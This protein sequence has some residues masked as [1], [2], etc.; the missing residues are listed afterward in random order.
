[1]RPLAGPLSVPGLPAHDRGRRAARAPVEATIVLGFN[2][3]AELERLVGD[4][5]NPGS[6]RFRRFLTRAQ[7]AARFSPTREQ[8]GR[9]LSALRAAGFTISQTYADRTQI[10][11]RGPSAVA[12]HF[13]STKIHDF[14]QRGTGVRY[15][16]VRA[17]RVPAS[18]A[19]LVRDV[20][21][22]SIVFARSNYA[23][24][25]ESVK[26]P[27]AI[28]NGGFEQKSLDWRACG[29]PVITTKHPYAG[30]YDAQLGSASK[31]AGEVHGLDAICQ[32]V[33]VPHAGVL[34]A[35][36]YTATNAEKVASSYQ[37][38]GLMSK[39]G[40]ILA[41]LSKNLT[42]SLHWKAES[43]QLQA[44]EGQQVYVFFAV[45]GK[46][47][48]N[49]YNTM[50]VDNVSLVGT[51]PTPT[52]SPTP[53]PTPTGPATPVGKGPGNPLTG[54][55]FGPNQA[56]APRGVADGF[57]LPVQHGYDGRGATVAYVAQAAIVKPDLDQFLNANG[58]SRHGTI[59]ETPVYG[60]PSGGD[61]T[62]GMIDVETIAALAPGANVIAYET[63][64]FS[65]AAILKAYQR[66]LNDGN[67]NVLVSTFGECDSQ[68]AS[69]DDASEQDAVEGAATGM[70]FVA[71]AGDQ[72]SSCYNA[73]TQKNVYGTEAPGSDP[74]FLAVGGSESVAPAFATSSPCPCPIATPIAWDDHNVNFG[75]VTGGGVSQQWAIPKYQRNVSGSPASTTHRNVPDIAFAA[76]DDDLRYA[77]IDQAIDGTSWSSSIA[78]ALLSEAIEICGPLGFVNPAAYTA[79]S[80]AGSNSA[81]IDVVAGFNGAYAPALPSGYHAAVGFDDVS[82]LGMPEGFNFAAALCGKTTKALESR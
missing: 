78:G 28:K 23:P 47:Q 39:P 81:F 53:S 9:V 34:L 11:A 67:A 82:G 2:H 56:W 36:T 74:D 10:D 29:K 33:T 52:P 35:H 30:K 14:D 75:G 44:Y 19:A 32:R 68:D 79:Q 22:N 12:E 49:L 31:S 38:I 3:V 4:L 63:P 69:F 37:E 42:N 20:E 27:D 8:Y 50:Y 80:V 51:V 64:D 61:P 71:S 65:N 40:T 58:V 72:G 24:A 13:F 18:I 17:I 41:V 21:L 77:A 55:T 6:A 1:M 26:T 16:N 46:G 43:W 59:T 48:E 60:G 66:A 15:A 57:D 70:T 5:S 45:F 7:F 62:E 73:T 76:V 25:D 54:P